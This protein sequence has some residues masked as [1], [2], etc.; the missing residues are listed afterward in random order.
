MDQDI[1]RLI[2]R[3][4]V[5]RGQELSYE[6]IAAAL[7]NEGFTNL[8]G[9]RWK[10]GA[11]ER[12][13][14]R[15]VLARGV[16][17]NDVSPPTRKR[18]ARETR[19]P[20]QT[21]GA[22]QMARGV[23]RGEAQE[24]QPEPAASSAGMLPP[25]AAPWFDEATAQDLRA[26]IEWWRREQKTGLKTETAEERPALVG[27]KKNTGIWVDVFVLKKAKMQAQK[28]KAGTGGSISSLV[29]KLLWEYVGSPQHDDQGR[30]LIEGTEARRGPRR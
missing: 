7:N 18:A 1:K 22:V 10:R 24:V 14:K 3:V 15:Y 12:F 8:E 17:T 21:G 29:E 25:P 5:L 27:P 23:S 26:L 9:G 16:T 28:D 2:A 13:Y 4:R 20:T 30:P 19:M 11:V 6:K